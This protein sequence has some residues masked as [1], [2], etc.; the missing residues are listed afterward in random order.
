MGLFSNFD[1]L[2]ETFWKELTFKIWWS[3]EEKTWKASCKHPN[4]GM[5]KG[6]SDLVGTS[7]VI[8]RFRSADDALNM[9]QVEVETFFEKTNRCK[10]GKIEY[11]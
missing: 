9:L 8:E 6:L 11:V 4:R 1:E 7:E 2:F 3:K 10:K 5:N